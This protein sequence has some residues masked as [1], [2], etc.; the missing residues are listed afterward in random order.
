ME[1]T[2]AI[3]FLAE[4]RECSQ[5]E[6]FRSYRTIPNQN[7][8]SN[9]TFICEFSDN[10][11]NPQKS[12]KLKA[13]G[14]FCIVFLPLIGAIEIS[15]SSGNNGSNILNSGEIRYFFVRD[16]TEILILNPYE[17][18]LV[19]YLEIW[20]KSPLIELYESFLS[21]FN[22]ELN[23]NKLLEI[24]DFNQKEKF[25]IGKFDGREEGFLDIV[26]N[27][28]VFV[29][30]GVFEVNNRLLEGRD[31]LFFRNVETIELEGLGVENII[32]I[33]GL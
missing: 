12:H 30:N 18:D 33:I 13:E 5:T 29:I 2:E 27:A 19:N 21:N 25:F 3:I 9:F 23:K 31:G 4:K 32:L 6:D 1:I 22:L 16:K 11:L 10:T 24:S 20:I 28:F 7:F 26:K 8:N 14:N 17:K 15:D